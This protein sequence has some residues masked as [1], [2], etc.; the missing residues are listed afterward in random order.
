MINENNF[1]MWIAIAF[2]FLPVIPLLILAYKSYKS[3]S[4]VK[5][6]MPGTAPWQT[7]WVKSEV[8]VPFVQNAWFQF[9]VIWL[10]LGALFFF[11]ALW[12]D[13]HDIWFEPVSK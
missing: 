4:V 11:G 2:C 1:D 12:P 7:R 10:I 6:H 8:K 5:E 9:A 3:G 13:H